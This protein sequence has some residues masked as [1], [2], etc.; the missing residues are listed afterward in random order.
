[1]RTRSLKLGART[2]REWMGAVHEVEVIDRGYRYEAATYKILSVIARFSI[3]AISSAMDLFRCYRFLVSFG[4]HALVARLL[5]SVAIG[6]QVLLGPLG[7]D[8][9]EANRNFTSGT[10]S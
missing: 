5:I 1:M 8:K 3:F 7:S 2:Y 10:E 4:R 9:R 6:E